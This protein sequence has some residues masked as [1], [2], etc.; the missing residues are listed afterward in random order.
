MRPVPI[1][2]GSPR[3][4]NMGLIS[5]SANDLTD[6]PPVPFNSINAIK[7]ASDVVVIGSGSHHPESATSFA[8]GVTEMSTWREEV[9]MYQLH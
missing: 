8:S 3:P 5:F 1:G 2:L 9:R 7:N 6:K 4:N